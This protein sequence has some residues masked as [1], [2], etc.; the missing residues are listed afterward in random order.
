M[1]LGR[2][3][4]T[5]DVVPLVRHGRLATRSLIDLRL[6]ISGT[7]QVTLVIAWCNGAITFRY[8]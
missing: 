7:H 8:R 2:H 4:R 3:R 5:V 1:S 6:P